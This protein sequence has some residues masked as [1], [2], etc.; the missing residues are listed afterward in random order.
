M[1][2]IININNGAQV[3]AINFTENESLTVYTY[4]EDY[5]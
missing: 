4:A 3:R 2:K 5:K 1:R